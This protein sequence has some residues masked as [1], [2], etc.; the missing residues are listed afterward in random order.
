VVERVLMERLLEELNIGTS[1]LADQNTALQL[2][3]VLA[4][5]LITTG[6]IFYLPNTTML[7]MRLIDTETTAVPKTFTADVG[8]QTT[9]DRQ[10]F[11]L[12]RDLLS[13]IIQKYPL[14]GYVVQSQ[15][16]TVMLNLGSEQGVVTGSRFSVVEETEPV[17]YKGRTLN[18]A[19]KI[20][21]ELEVVTVEPD[22]SH[23]RI[24]QKQRALKTDDKVQEVLRHAPGN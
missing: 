18:K 19:P 21:G 5:K 9:L 20:I 13:T 15:D 4:A 10:L 11:D 1:A 8:G 22:L 17:V 12:N 14:R 6:S 7:S 16:D 23:A 24:I 2:G 3:R